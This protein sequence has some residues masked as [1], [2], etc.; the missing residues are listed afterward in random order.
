MSDVGNS[1]TIVHAPKFYKMYQNIIQLRLFFRIAKSQTA[2][3][4]PLH[5]NQ[6]NELLA[7]KICAFFIVRVKL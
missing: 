6:T 2:D 3:D 4:L 7:A 1:I 5:K